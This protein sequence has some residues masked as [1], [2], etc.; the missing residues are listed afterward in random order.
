MNI[1]YKIEKPLLWLVDTFYT[2]WPQPFPGKENLAQCKIV[3]HRGQCDNRHVFEN[4]MKAFEQAEA[5][6]VWGFEFDIRWTKD[7]QPVVIHDP[8]LIRVFGKS[9]RVADVTCAD[10]RNQC[11]EIPLL[12]EMIQR[13]GKKL[14]LMVEIKEEIYPDPV[15][16]NQILKT[17]F[18]ALK[19]QADYHLLSL[20]EKMFDVID[21][22]PPSVFLPVSQ[23]NYK[24]FSQ[25]AV[26]RAFCGVAGHYLF[27]SAEL[28]KK[29]HEHK[30]GMGTGY[31]SSRN[32]LFREINRGVDWIF[33]NNAGEMQTILNKS[34]DKSKLMNS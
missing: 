21:F 11:P 28:L 8:D 26:E 33:S 14:H 4:T 10:L 6:G 17:H 19:P 2:L 27:M 13:F 1:L 12:E 32:C 23:L 22:V 29:Q 34:I 16:Q 24:H 9:I 20:S 5:S 3:S 30:Q 25:L 7:L 31:I 18:A 15:R